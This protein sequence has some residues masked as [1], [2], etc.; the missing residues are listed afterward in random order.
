MCACMETVVDVLIR[1]TVVNEFQV[2]WMMAMMA[3]MMMMMM[4]MMILPFVNLSTLI[5]KIFSPIIA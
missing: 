1:M 4:M 2:V 5:K 3:M